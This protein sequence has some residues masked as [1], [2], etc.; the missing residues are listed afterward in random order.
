MNSPVP[1]LIT[2]IIGIAILGYVYLTARHK[3]RMSMI[4]KGVDASLF[5]SKKNRISPTLKLGMLAIGVALGVIA[6]MILVTKLD[7]PSGEPVLVS[8]VLL[9]GGISL[10]ANFFIERKMD[11]G[12]ND[13]KEQE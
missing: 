1:V 12:S 3:E 6:T 8:M 9:F 2:G 4:D 11:S 13:K 5:T 10:I 7:P